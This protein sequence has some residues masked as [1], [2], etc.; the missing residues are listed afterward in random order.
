M[1]TPR[2]RAAAPEMSAADWLLLGL[3]SVIWGGSF[4]FAKVAVEDFGPMTV[5]LGRVGLAAVIL[6]LL[7]R[8]RGLRLPATFAG[9]RPFI[10]MGIINSALPYTLIFWGEVHIASGL[11][12][13]LNATT[14]IFTLLVAHVF[15]TDERLTPGKVGG[16]LLGMLG[17]VVI[18][19]RALRRLRQSTAPISPAAPRGERHSTERTTP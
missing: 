15:T 6:N 18:D 3:L 1:T 9:W 8:S 10:V 13:I 14:P 11:A 19:G 4:F 7:I 12:A 16:V 5:V 2:G 17:V